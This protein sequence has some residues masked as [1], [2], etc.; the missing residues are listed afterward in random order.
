MDKFFMLVKQIIIFSKKFL[1]IYYALAGMKL[2]LYKLK[3]IKK[4]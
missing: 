2:L 1:I 4:Y 3:Q